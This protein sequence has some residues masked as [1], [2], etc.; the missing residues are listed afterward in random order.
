M[1][2]TDKFLLGIVAGIIVL[3]VAVFVIAQL[4]PN[5]PSYD[6]DDTPEGVAYNYLLSVQLM[7]Y[8][9]AYGYLSSDLVGYPEN[10]DTFA[11]EVD[12]PWLLRDGMDDDISLIVDRVQTKGDW[13]T[14]SILHV[15]FDRGG[16]FDSGERTSIVNVDLRLTADGW[17][18]ARANRY[19]NRCWSDPALCK[20]T[21][22]PPAN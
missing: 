14:V 22:A 8:E 19:W 9:R 13:A 21:P 17:R 6:Q 15:W 7:D 18:I 12:E 16:L 11:V 2:G 20:A 5:E 4:R 3:V 1:Q 10:V